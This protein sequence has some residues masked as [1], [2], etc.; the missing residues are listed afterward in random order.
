MVKYQC[1]T[2]L[3]RIRIERYIADGLSKTDISKK[4]NRHK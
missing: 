3:E 1:L 2:L 4:L